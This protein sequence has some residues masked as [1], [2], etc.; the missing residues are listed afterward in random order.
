M[1]TNEKILKYLKHLWKH[2][3]SDTNW[4]FTISLVRAKSQSSC[5]VLKRLDH[6]KFKNRTEKKYKTQRD[7][8]PVL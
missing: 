8:K 6:I 2:V 1:I 7:E 5:Y 4:S 3:F